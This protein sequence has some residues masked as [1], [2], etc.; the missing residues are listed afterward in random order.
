[1]FKNM[2]VIPLPLGKRPFMCMQNPASYLGR[3]SEIFWLPDPCSPIPW[4]G[5]IYTSASPCF[6]SNY[7]GEQRTLLELWFTFYMFAQLSND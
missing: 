4:G 2:H 5:E 1:M 6:P 3:N 7:T